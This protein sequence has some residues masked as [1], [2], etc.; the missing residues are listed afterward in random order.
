MKEV[1]VVCIDVSGSMGAPF[2]S[3]R[4][5]LEAVKQM[6]Y[7]FRD[8]TTSYE[9]G[10]SHLIGLLSYDQ[11]IHVHSHPT[12]NL[13]LFEAVID[14]MK[15]GGSTAIYDAIVEA[16]NLLHPF[17]NSSETPP[18]STPDLRVICLSD[19]QNNASV[20]LPTAALSAL[21]NIEAVCDCLIVGNSPDHNLLRLCQ[22]TGGLSFQIN[23]L[24]DGYEILE[25][26][27]VV[28]LYERRN[29]EERG[30]YPKRS[31]DDVRQGDTVLIGAE[32]GKGKE[33]PTPKPTIPCSSVMSMGTALNLP[34]NTQQ[35]KRI[36]KE[37]SEFSLSSFHIFPC[38]QDRVEHIRVLME[39]EI[40]TPF[41]NGIF[42]LSIT[43]PPD[44]PFK[45]LKIRFVTPIYHYAVG[46]DG[47]VCLDILKDK[48]SPAITF[49]KVLS[50][51]SEI[52]HHSD[53]IDPDCNYSL[54]AWLSELLRVNK[55]EYLKNAAEATK[56]NAYT[57][58]D[59]FKAKNNIS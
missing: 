39:G 22:A 25:S 32:K 5:R 55:Q 13:D 7:G 44:Y 10:S 33:I 8:A 56:R 6:F 12:K 14:N 38:G 19:G 1:I 23:T 47:S 11:R 49:S 16:C 3:D 41:E 45:P 54:R 48:W 9:F 27:S 52:V 20:N 58:I 35:Q 30:V 15:T 2:E 36:K 42:E 26:L 37:I 4:N 57:S 46:Q 53:K 28:S 59:D 21:Q 40:G 29:K 43:F 50:L 51:I 18:L 17:V 24:S 31:L 34:T